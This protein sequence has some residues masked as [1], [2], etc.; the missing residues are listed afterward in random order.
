M[1]RH[2]FFQIFLINRMLERQHSLIINFSPYYL[3]KLKPFVVIQPSSSKF[4]KAQVV[5]VVTAKFKW[6]SFFYFWSGF[7]NSAL[8]IFKWIIMWTFISKIYI[9]IISTENH[10]L[11][12]TPI[13]G[14]MI[15]GQEIATRG[16][17]FWF[18]RKIF[19]LPNF[20]N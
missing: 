17:I 4:Y 1:N 16:K 6:A 20:E 13:M 5:K 18:L 19:R 11:K 8:K 9:Y 14:S 12:S 2:K 3:K 10:F 7:I 15:D